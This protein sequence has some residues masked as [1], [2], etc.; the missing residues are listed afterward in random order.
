MQYP[1]GSCHPARRYDNRW[2][3]DLI[4]P[5]G[6]IAGFA[7]TQ[8]LRVENVFT[9][10][11]EDHHFF[12]NQDVSNM[13]RTYQE[14]ESAK[15]LIITTEKDA[16]RLEKHHAFL[17]E[18]KLPIFVLPV[19]VYFHFGESPQFDQLMKDFLLNFKV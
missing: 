6:F 1:P 11:Y 16:V 10:E 18:N 17:R 8:L 15:K 13:V 9:L 7:H 12:T 4:D 19:E 3:F 5:F 2:S 14:M